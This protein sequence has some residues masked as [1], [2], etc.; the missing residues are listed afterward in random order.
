MM[1]S[2][3]NQHMKVTF[4]GPGAIGYPMAGHVAAEDD[5]TVWNRTFTRAERHASDFGRKT[6]SRLASKGIAFIDAPVTGGTP[7]AAAGTLTVM[8][9]G[10]SEDH[11]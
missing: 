10:S 7:G 11:V 5:R 4:I 8:V 3:K 6:A 2:R 1:L 9:G